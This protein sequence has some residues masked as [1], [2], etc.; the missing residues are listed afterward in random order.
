MRAGAPHEV[1]QKAM[2]VKSNMVGYYATLKGE[3]LA[4][5]SK[6]AF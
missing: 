3:D 6:L 1:V 4:K 2:R 5:V